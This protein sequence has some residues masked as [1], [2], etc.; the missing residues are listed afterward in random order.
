MREGG[1]EGWREGET[2]IVTCAL[3][4]GCP[5][6][7]RNESQANVIAIAFAMMVGTIKY[8]S[9]PFLTPTLLSFPTL[10]SSPLSLPLPPHQ[11]DGDGPASEEAGQDV[12]PVVAVL[13]HPDHAHQQGEARRGGVGRGVEGEVSVRTGVE[14]EVRVRTGVE[15]EGEERC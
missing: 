13:G 5:Q 11:K 15:G 12:G 2:L 7:E 9:L 6:N 10:S 3:A 8:H 1:G 14:G 4:S